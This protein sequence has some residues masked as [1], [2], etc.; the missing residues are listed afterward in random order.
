MDEFL[1]LA[2]HREQALP[3]IIA[4]FFN[5]VG[6]RQSGEYGMVLPRFVQA[7]LRNQPLEVFG[8]GQQTRCFCHVLDTV[9]A[10][11][12]LQRTPAAIGQI[13]NIGSIHEIS[14]VDLAQTVIDV[15]G[16]GSMKFVP[17]DTAYAPGFE[18]MIRRRPSVDKLAET[19]GFRPA[20]TLD[21][22]I[23]STV[24]QREEAPGWAP[25]D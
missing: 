11:I 17:Y 14:I 3:V 22:I 7:A 4:R 21:E 8:D 10:L 9:E 18:D 25:L 24:A 20:L 5:T 6:P 19:T 12:R 15:V 23:R 16:S 13:F 1:G 2:Y